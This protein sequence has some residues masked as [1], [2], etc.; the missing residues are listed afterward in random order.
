MIN[1]FI[2]EYL[3]REIKEIENS[4]T[5]INSV[6]N[7]QTSRVVQ[8]VKAVCS[9]LGNTEPLDISKNLSVFV[10]TCNGTSQVKFLYCTFNFQ[11]SFDVFLHTKFKNAAIIHILKEK[12]LR[13]LLMC[14]QLYSVSNKD[15]IY[16]YSYV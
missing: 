3:E 9:L 6:G 7:I 11:Y 16:T 10:D 4:A 2:V 12:N 1:I 13:I 14:N 15:A 5:D 8:A